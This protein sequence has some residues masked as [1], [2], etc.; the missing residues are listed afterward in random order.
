MID[1]FSK[2]N[3][4]LNSAQKIPVFCAFVGLWYYG[5]IFSQAGRLIGNQCVFAVFPTDIYVKLFIDGVSDKGGF[6]ISD[7][8][9]FYPYPAN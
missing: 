4:H 5:H 7:C 6:S 3:S 9:L 8:Q 2:R 1:F